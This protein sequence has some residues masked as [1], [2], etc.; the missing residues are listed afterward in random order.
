[1]SI[2]SSDLISLALRLSAAD[3]E[4]EW[5]SGASRAYYAAYH[6][7]L[8]AANRCLAPVSA[9]RGYHERL[10]NRLMDY[11]TKGRSIAYTLKA[12]K[13]GRTRADY[14]L[15]TQFSQKEATE[16]VKATI[17]FLPKVD[18][19]E[20]HVASCNASMAT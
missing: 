13:H 7:A 15:N 19:F 14:E 1:M 10:T 4:C 12:L 5:R 8:N 2:D 11:G 17:E 20:A 3:T 18:A 16:L 9:D 6:K